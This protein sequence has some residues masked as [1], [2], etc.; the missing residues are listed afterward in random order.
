MHRLEEAI[1]PGL[2]GEMDVRH[3]LRQLAEATDQIVP[4]TDRMR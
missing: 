4:E 1:G 2:K 3:E